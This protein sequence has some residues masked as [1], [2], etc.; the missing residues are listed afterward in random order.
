MR[1]ITRREKKKRYFLEQSFHQVF[2]KKMKKHVKR[3]LN[4]KST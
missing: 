2:F 4:K 1:Q 3:I